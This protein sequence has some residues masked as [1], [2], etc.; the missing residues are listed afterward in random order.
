MTISEHFRKTSNSHTS[1]TGIMLTSVS[2]LTSMGLDGNTQKLTDFH[3]SKRADGSFFNFCGPHVTTNEHLV[4][5]CEAM[6]PPWKLTKISHPRGTISAKNAL[7]PSA[8]PPPPTRP[9]ADTAATRP[10][11]RLHSP[12]RPSTPPP[13]GCPPTQLASPAP[14]RPPTP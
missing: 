10:P 8:R 5:F 3:D 11:S 14:A 6:N 7:H 9:T 1:T 12:A 4:N 2:Y 13:P